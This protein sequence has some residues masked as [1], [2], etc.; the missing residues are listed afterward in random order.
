M[1]EIIDKLILSTVDSE[2]APTT[3]AVTVEVGGDN[4]PLPIPQG[5]GYVWLDVAD[6]VEI[7]VARSAIASKVST[8]SADAQTDSKK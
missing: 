1:T 4:D 2:V 7:R 8:P 5:G 6:E 3:V